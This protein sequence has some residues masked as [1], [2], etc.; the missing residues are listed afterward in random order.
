MLWDEAGPLF[1]DRRQAGERLAEL[2][3]DLGPRRGVILGVPRGGVVV[4][5]P[6]A[7]R[8]GW[9]LDVIL[10]RKVGTPFNP[11]LAAGAVA[12]DGV[13]R[14]NADVLRYLFGATVGEEEAR[15]LLLPYLRE[16]REELHRRLRLYR[17][18]RPPLR[19]AGLTVVVVDDGIATGLTVAA[20]LDWLAG[21]GP[22]ARIL[23]TPVASPEAL[24]YLTP[25]CD[26]LVCLAAPHPFF[27]VG[28]YYAD[29]RQVTDEEVQ[30]ILR[31]HGP[32]AG[33]AGGGQA[34]PDAAGGPP[35]AE[36][37]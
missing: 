34:G 18:S 11:E 10:A 28:Q 15:E 21:Q 37:P 5:A 8:L 12:P 36:P 7:E 35:P 2:L 26:Q 32:P 30:E 4:A 25:L 29:F 16:A 14:W 13:C 6:V 20:A 17:G 24:E 23:A 3:A 19:L 31:T 22:A 9:P 27:A 1:P 33:R